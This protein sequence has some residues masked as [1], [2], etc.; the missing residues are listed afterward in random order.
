MPPPGTDAAY[1][2]ARE[3]TRLY[4]ELGDATRRI[5]ELEALG[6]DLSSRLSAARAEIEALLLL[7]QRYLQMLCRAKDVWV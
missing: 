4:A 1:R 7:S 3:V 6:A 5:E 2:Q